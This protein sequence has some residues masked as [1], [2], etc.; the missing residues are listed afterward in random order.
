MIAAMSLR[1]LLYLIFHAMIR[2]PPADVPHIPSQGCQAGR[3]RCSPDPTRHEGRRASGAGLY[4]AMSGAGLSGVRRRPAAGRPG[5]N[6]DPGWEGLWVPEPSH[7]SGQRDRCERTVW[8]PRTV[9]RSLMSVF[10]AGRPSRSRLANGRAGSRAV[11]PS[12]RVPDARRVLSWLSLLA[13]SDAAKDVEILM[14]RHEVA[15]VGRHPHAQGWTGSTA[16]CSGR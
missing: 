14:L 10:A 2:L 7:G 15:M 3:G 1:L 8:V 11:A 4:A 12:T 13:R 6:T 9:S 5:G 16:Q